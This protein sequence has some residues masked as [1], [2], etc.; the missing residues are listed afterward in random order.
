MCGGYNFS[1]ADVCS[2][3]LCAYCGIAPFCFSIGV[4]H[5]EGNNC[6]ILYRFSAFAFDT[7]GDGSGFKVRLVFG[8]CCLVVFLIEVCSR[9]NRVFEYLDWVSLIWCSADLLERFVQASGTSFTLHMHK[10]SELLPPP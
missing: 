1:L 6:L 3:L 4:L 2:L 7:M 10:V 8:L 9:I 5:S